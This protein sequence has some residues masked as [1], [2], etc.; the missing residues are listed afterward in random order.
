MAYFQTNESAIWSANAQIAIEVCSFTFLGSADSHR[1]IILSRTTGTTQILNNTFRGNGASTPSTAC[2]L[3]TGESIN[4]NNYSEGTF[5]FSNNT[6]DGTAI[7]RV[8]I[9][10]VL[11][12]P[13]S[14]F[15]MYFTDNTIL[16]NTDFFILYGDVTSVGI[17]EIVLSNNNVSL[18]PTSS[19]FKGLIGLDMPTPPIPITII[20]FPRIRASRNTIPTTIRS[21]YTPFDQC[22]NELA[23]VCYRASK[24]SHETE[25][26]V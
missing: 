9:M 2:V 1:Y 26:N 22:S 17:S 21:D 7:Q 18:I 4:S 5:I 19:G 23:I 15:K 6:S 11:P 24:F 13:Y 3:F 8:G 16:T 10:E 14:N 12:S 20:E 25:V